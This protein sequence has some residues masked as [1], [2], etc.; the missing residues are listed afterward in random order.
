[1]D[2]LLRELY[3]CTAMGFEVPKPYL[4]ALCRT[5]AALDVFPVGEPEGTDVSTGYCCFVQGWQ[6]GRLRCVPAN[7]GWGGQCHRCLAPLIMPLGW[8]HL[9]I[10]DHG[11]PAAGAGPSAADRGARQQHAQ[12]PEGEGMT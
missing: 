7:A 1:M 8:D 5:V 4:L 10:T 2:L 11:T 3:V 9:C 12:G 6:A